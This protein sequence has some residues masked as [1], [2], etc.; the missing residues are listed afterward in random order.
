[1]D[2]SL[3]QL[4]GTMNEKYAGLTLHMKKSKWKL[5]NTRICNV[6]CIATCHVER[7]L[8]HTTK[9]LAGL[10]LWNTDF[11]ISGVVVDWEDNLATKNA[12]PWV[13]NS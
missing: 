6:Y 2:N 11:F 12:D 1:M 5:R 7:P 8:Q 9:H 3:H 4:R 13:Q 10:S